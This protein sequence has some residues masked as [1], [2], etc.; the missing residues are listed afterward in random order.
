[1]EYLFTFWACYM[2]YKE[3]DR[4][5]SMRLSFLASQGR[6]PAQFTV[7]F[8]ALMAIYIDLLSTIMLNCTCSHERT[9]AYHQEPFTGSGV[10]LNF[11]VM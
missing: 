8:F 11:R 3:Y 6:Q 5:A 2:L 4:V 7:S 9:N 10:I 1:M